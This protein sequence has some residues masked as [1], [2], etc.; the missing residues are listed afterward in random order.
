M[1]RT[2]VSASDA[3]WC[4]WMLVNVCIDL[5]SLLHLVLLRVLSGSC[6]EEDEL[7]LVFL[8]GRRGTAM[9]RPSGCRQS[10]AQKGH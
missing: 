2:S 7:G 8:K 3:R 5:S 1:C 6:N 10:V 9:M 4:D